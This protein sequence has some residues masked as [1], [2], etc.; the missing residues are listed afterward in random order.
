[1]SPNHLFILDEV[2]GHH[3]EVDGDALEGDDTCLKYDPGNVIRL[4][5]FTDVT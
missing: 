5:F 4:L 1:M 3:G 2:V